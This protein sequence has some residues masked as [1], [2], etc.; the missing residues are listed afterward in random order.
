M[1]VF[2]HGFLLQG[3][4]SIDWVPG[5][6]NWRSC[7]SG[8]AV[9]LLTPQLSPIY[10]IKRE[11][12]VGNKNNY[13]AITFRL[14]LQSPGQRPWVFFTYQPLPDLKS[15]L[16][17]GDMKTLLLS[18]M[19]K[20]IV[21]SIDFESPFAHY[22]YKIDAFKGASWPPGSM[23]VVGRLRRCLL[24]LYEGFCALRV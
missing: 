8:P 10:Y 3:S 22:G 4:Q 24:L 14:T 9:E 18:F 17:A 20:V 19:S 23:R 7:Y 11:C 15:L 2:Q 1:I 5:T 6:V 12:V 16:L 21:P 13:R